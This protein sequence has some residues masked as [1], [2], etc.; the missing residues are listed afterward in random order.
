MANKEPFTERLKEQ[1]VNEPKEI[2]VKDQIS[3]LTYAELAIT[4]LDGGSLY[5][6]KPISDV[7]LRFQTLISGAIFTQGN[8]RLDNCHGE[9]HSHFQGSVSAVPIS[10]LNDAFLMMCGSSWWRENE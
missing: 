5:P 9:M 7:K 2:R 3:G 6:A 10:T 1:I 4:S 8:Y